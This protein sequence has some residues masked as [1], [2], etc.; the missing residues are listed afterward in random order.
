MHAQAQPASLTWSGTPWSC[1]TPVSERNVNS[2]LPSVNNSIS[3][4][5]SSL[6]DS[7]RRT[8]RCPACEYMFE[9]YTLQ[10][11]VLSQSAMVTPIV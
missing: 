8:T 4:C 11:P 6:S 2:W 3:A 1:H 5:I 10:S 9:K 7:V